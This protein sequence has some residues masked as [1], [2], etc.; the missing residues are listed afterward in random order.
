MNSDTHFEYAGNL[1]I[2]SLYSDGAGTYPEII[3]SAQ[4][5]GLDFI[6]FNDH[7][8]MTDD[9]HLDKEGFYK[10]IL[11][12]SGLEIGKRYHHYL[13]YDLKEMVTGQSSG[14]QEIIDLVNAQGGFGFLAHPFEKG[15][16]FKENSLAYTWN[17]LSVTGYTGIC[18][19]NFS[20]R[21][22]ERIKT[23]LHGIF[24]LLF[25]SQTLKG[26]SRKTL[27]FWDKLCL[28]RRVAAIGGSDAHATLFRWGLIRIKPL[29]YDFLLNSINVHI[30]LN[31]ELSTDVAGAKA[32]VYNAL[33]QGRLFIVNEKLGGARGFRFYYVSEDGSY[34]NMGQ[35]ERFKPGTLFIETPGPGKITLIRN[36]NIQKSRLGQKMSYR[37]KE[38]GV[39]RVEIRRRVFLFGWRPWI[40]SN[41]I[42]LR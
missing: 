1:H 30:L 5:A 28:E 42:Y 40:F 31:R 15:M 18:I 24:C 4:R 16:P 29:S 8:H 14:P 22:K 33:R 36:G 41:P 21:W 25:K 7:A 13:A 38:K 12:L 17:D 6:V 37:I 3:Q 27:Y 11:V 10:G 2:H 39:Y 26:P 23:P 19:W 32:E 9:L 34:L 20:S 35:E